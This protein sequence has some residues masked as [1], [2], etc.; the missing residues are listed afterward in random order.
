MATKQLSILGVFGKPDSSG[1]VWVEPYSIGAT[2]DVWDFLIIKF[3][4]TATLDKFYGRFRI[5]DDYVGTAVIHVAWTAQNTSGNTVWEFA[6]RVVAA[7]SS[8]DQSGATGIEAVSVTSAAPGSTDLLVEAT[9][10]LTS[11]NLSA[12]SYL[13]FWIARDNTSG[14]NNMNAAATLIDVVLYYVN[15]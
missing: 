1:N 3:A 10:A 9:I 13:E 14:S 12:G 15:V 5:P 7:G 4:K 11:A 6:Y 2:N 8:L